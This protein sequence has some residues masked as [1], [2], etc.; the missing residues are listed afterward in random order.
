[1]GE[2]RRVTI[3]EFESEMKKD[4]KSI[5]VDLLDFTT[6]KGYLRVDWVQPPHGPCVSCFRVNNKLLTH[7]PEEILYKIIKD[8]YLATD[9]PDNV[10]GQIK[11]IT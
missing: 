7:S 1:M 4:L 9:F 10:R 6:C 8:I 2:V 3:E 11:E 5:G